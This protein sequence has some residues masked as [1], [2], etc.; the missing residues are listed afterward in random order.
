MVQADYLMSRDDSR[1]S[2]F[3]EE[4]LQMDWHEVEATGKMT[5]TMKDL[6]VTVISL[7][8]SK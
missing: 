8:L 7:S 3:Q 1:L 6:K 5:K 4:C 2:G